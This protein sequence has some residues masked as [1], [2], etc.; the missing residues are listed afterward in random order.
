MSKLLFAGTSSARP[1]YGRFSCATVLYTN[2]GEDLYLIDC[3]EGTT[4]VLTQLQVPLDKIRGVII[5]HSHADHASGIAG[6]IHSVIFTTSLSFTVVAP[7]GI[8]KIIDSLFEY[9]GEIVPQQI[10]YIDLSDTEITS[11]SIKNTTF[12]SIPIPHFKSICGHGIICQIENII[13]NENSEKKTVVFTGDTN[14]SSKLVQYTKDHSIDV[15]VFIHE[16]TFPREMEVSAQKWGHSTP[17]NIAQVLP[18][19]NPKCCILHHY[20]TR[21][22][23][24]Q[25]KHFAEE[26]QK[27]TNIKTISAFDEMIFEF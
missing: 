21:L 22:T 6:F 14:D 8:R 19:M 24:P 26:I 23:V 9:A 7:K 27:E 25:I 20:S 16:C 12:T 2:N 4:N 3:G 5:T 10:E 11:F 17:V 1:I 18:I 15:D 13:E